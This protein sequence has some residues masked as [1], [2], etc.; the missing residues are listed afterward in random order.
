MPG[1]PAIRRRR[2]VIQ[3]DRWLRLGRT[4]LLASLLL[5]GLTACGGESK[6][7]Q[8]S[9]TSRAEQAATAEAKQKPRQ[10]DPVDAAEA[11]DERDWAV[12]QIELHP[13]VDGL[14]GE[15]AAQAAA[16]VVQGV[17]QQYSASNAAVAFGVYAEPSRSRAWLLEATRVMTPDAASGWREAASKATKADEKV[18]AGSQLSEVLWSLTTY[19]AFDSVDDLPT[20]STRAFE[21]RRLNA[22]NVDL[23]ADGRLHVTATVTARLNESKKSWK[24][25]HSM[26]F[27]MVGSGTDWKLDGW[28]GTYDATK[29]L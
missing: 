27:W 2:V 14:K 22:L 18:E 13:R 1:L 21:N 24:F 5:V 25:R 9:D 12:G 4:P 15:G 19:K 11:D 20:G 28:N 7:V 29:R 26:E 6:A 16:D 8:N 17:L 10:L 3:P 23:A